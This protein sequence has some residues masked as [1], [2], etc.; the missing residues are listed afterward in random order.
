MVVENFSKGFQLAAKVYYLAILPFL[1][2]LI[3]LTGRALEAFSSNS[4]RFGVKFSFPDHFPSLTDF[5]AFPAPSGLQTSVPDFRGGTILALL[6]VVALTVVVSLVSAGYL[7]KMN[8]S[9]LG[10]SSSLLSNASKYFVR[11]LVY[12]VFILALVLV[13]VFLAFALIPLAILYLFAFFFIYYLVLL[14]PFGIVV[15]N[16]RFGEAL[17]RSI[18]LMTSRASKTLPYVIIYLVLTA[19][20]SVPAYALMNA[21]GI[22][23]LFAVAISALV[24]T[25]LV[26]STLQLYIQ[27]TQ[28]PTTPTTLP[29]T[30][31]IPPNPQAPP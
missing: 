1:M 12:D 7:G 24:G 31:P 20:V 18:N 16:L 3:F 21:G 17:N 19:L 9:S 14:T 13:E 26:G 15:D 5:Y 10:E 2:D 8:A 22:G 4:V 6:Y 25:A 30:P 23:F 27:V 28:P 29:P 11:I